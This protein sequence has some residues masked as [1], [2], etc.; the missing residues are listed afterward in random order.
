MNVDIKILDDRLKDNGWMPSYA[1]SGDAGLDLRA[2]IDTDSITLPPGEVINMPSG[3]AVDMGNRGDLTA[4]MLPRSGLG[5]RG[6][7][8]GNLVGLID[9]GYQ[10]Q[11]TLCMWNRSY[12]DITIKFGERIAQLVFLPV[13]QPKLSV[14]EAFCS[15]T[16]RGEGG[17]GSSGSH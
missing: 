1:N 4:V 8:L 17:F 6:L 12:A 14:V 2:M 16:D 3:I 10:G 5:S 15:D 13:I 9:S 7:V 11:I